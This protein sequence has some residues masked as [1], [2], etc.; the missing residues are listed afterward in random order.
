MLCQGIARIS[1]DVFGRAFARLSADADPAGLSVD[2]AAPA[3]PVGDAAPE[4]AVDAAQALAAGDAAPDLVRPLEEF[5]DAFGNLA[6]GPGSRRKHFQRPVWA[7]DQRRG[8]FKMLWMSSLAKSKRREKR[9]E[10]RD[11]K[12][13][14]VQKFL[15]NRA[16]RV[17]D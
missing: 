6:A 11:K 2:G 5:A 17:G 15:A 12:L 13:V 8:R 1:D 4:A 16:L 7:G 10:A 9:K 14:P 3:V